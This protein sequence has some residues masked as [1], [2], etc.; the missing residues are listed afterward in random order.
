MT[1][2]LHNE[3]N[4]LLLGLLGVVIFAATL[5]MTKMAVGSMAAPQRCL[6]C[7]CLCNMGVGNCAYLLRANGV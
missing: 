4:G 5:P 7:T 3:R 2:T 1:T 6:L